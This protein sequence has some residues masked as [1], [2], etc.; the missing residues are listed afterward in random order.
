[1]GN[2]CG[3]SPNTQPTDKQHTDEKK[4]PQE[5]MNPSTKS[6]SIEQRQN[7]DEWD[8]SKLTRNNTKLIEIRPDEENLKGS[9]K[10][11]VNVED[12]K[13]H[14]VRLL[15]HDVTNKKNRYLE[16]VLLGKLFSLKKYPRVNYMQ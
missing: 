15:C 8:I 13:F 11:K 10:K 1:M 4:D 6:D 14:K 2:F 9:Q 5:P 7:S 12:F 16:K 3:C